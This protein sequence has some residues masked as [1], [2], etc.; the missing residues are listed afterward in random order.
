MSSR[1][2]PASTWAQ[3]WPIRR[4]FAQRSA[5]L[6]LGADQGIGPE[7]KFSSDQLHL[8][9]YARQV[10]PGRA[11]LVFGLKGHSFTIDNHA[12][13]QVVSAPRTLDY[14]VSGRAGDLDIAQSSL[15]NAKT[16]QRQ[17][18][19]NVRRYGYAAFSSNP[20]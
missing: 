20:P 19:I 5:G 17:P 10:E 1:G 8:L 15:T 3:L 9:F 13:P 11:V 2:L 12:Q 16:N 18:A 4:G 6:Q 7:A 14:H